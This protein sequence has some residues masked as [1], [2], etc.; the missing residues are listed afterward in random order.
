MD[1][2]DRAEKLRSSFLK[3]PLK[4][5]RPVVRRDYALYHAFFNTLPKPQ[6]FWERLASSELANAFGPHY[7]FMAAVKCLLLAGYPHPLREL[8]P[9]LQ[10]DTA[11]AP[12][13][14]PGEMFQDFCDCHWDRI[15]Q[16]ALSRDVQINKV[17][18]CALFLPLFAEV[19]QR[20]G[21]RPLALIEVG[22]SAGFGLLWPHLGYDYGLR[23]RVGPLDSELTLRCRV[24]GKREFLVPPQLP[25][26]VRQVGL[27]LRPFDLTNDDVRW[28]I[29]LTAPNNL[30]NHQ[31]VRVA[32]DLARRHAPEIR[33]GCVLETLE[34]AFDALPGDATCVVFHSLTTHHLAEQRKLARYQD[35]LRHLARRRRFFQATVEWNAYPTDY[36]KPLPLRLHCWENGRSTCSDLGVT[37][38]AADGRWVCWA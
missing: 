26:V 32:I 29:A 31:Q 24:L 18:R 13:V 2:N 16:L 30:A 10:A 21:R 27:E 17:S 11:R 15:I 20:G 4:G 35:L 7:R 14:V 3:W 6:Q 36:G 1:L 38:P 12:A 37:D 25:P 5:N 8:Y 19:F 9:D 33:P 23:G 22:S 28:L 34:S